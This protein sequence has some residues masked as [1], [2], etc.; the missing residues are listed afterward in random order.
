M[1]LTGPWSSDGHEA[2]KGLEAGF[3]PSETSLISSSQAWEGRR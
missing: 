2:Q 3:I 1:L